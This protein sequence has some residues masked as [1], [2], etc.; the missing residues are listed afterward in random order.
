MLYAPRRTSVDA[1]GM[2][3]FG[4]DKAQ[5]TP[6]EEECACDEVEDNRGVGRDAPEVSVHQHNEAHHDESVSRV[7]REPVSKWGGRTFN[8]H[9][10]PPVCPR[11]SPPS[12]QSVVVSGATSGVCGSMVSGGLD[13]RL[14]YQRASSVLPIR[15]IADVHAEF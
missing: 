7:S 4:H 9:A 11:S 1:S 15:A 6:E 2:M 13:L 10:E 5:G 12:L 3:A 14:G 8:R